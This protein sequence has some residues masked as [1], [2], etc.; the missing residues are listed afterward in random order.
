LMAT[1]MELAKTAAAAFV[2]EELKRQ[3]ECQD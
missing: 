3:G 1:D 2:T